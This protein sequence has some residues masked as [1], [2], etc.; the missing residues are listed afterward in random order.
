MKLTSSAFE[1]RGQIPVSYTRDGENASPP[2]AWEE[3]PEGTAELA[4]I[5]EC[6][7]PSSH[8]SFTQWLLYGI[9]PSRPGLPERVGPKRNRDE[10]SEALNGRN[11]VGN[12]GYDGPLGSA[13]KRVY[14]VFRL[15][16]LDR[17]SGLDE[18]ANR[19]TLDEAT[20][21]H[22]LAEAELGCVYDRP[23]V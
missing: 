5:F 12:V 17:P 14:Y 4:V 15:L 3:V 20:R 11:S 8:P 13:G 22:I 2:L 10:P 6:D 16:A 1:N 19:E 21:G 9:A 7:T 23:P 18:G